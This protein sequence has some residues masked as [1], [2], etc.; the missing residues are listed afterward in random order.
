MATHY[1]AEEWP[2][3]RFQNIYI[4]KQTNNNGNS[5]LKGEHLKLV[6][7][8]KAKDATKSCRRTSLTADGSFGMEWNGIVFVPLI[9]SKCKEQLN[10]SMNTVGN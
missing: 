1:R 9:G 2:Q 8:G 10:S 6:F 7:N 5:S 3:A 4:L